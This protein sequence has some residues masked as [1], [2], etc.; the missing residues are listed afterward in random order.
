VQRPFLGTEA[1]AAG[2]VNRYQLATRHDALFRNVYVPKGHAV[3]PVDKAVGA[4]LWS[5]RCATAAGMS[6]AALHG[7]KWIDATLPAE[8]NQASRHRTANILL[9]SDFLADD[10]ICLVRGISATTPARTAFDLGRR[11]GLATAVMRLDALRQATRL[12]VD[13]VHALVGRHRGARGIVQLR[14]ALALSDAKAESPQET[15]TRLVLTDAG[16]RPTHTQIEVYD[17]DDFVARI[18]MGYL[19]WKVGVEYDGP[20][21]WTDSRVRDRDLERRARLAALDWRIVHVNAEM[22]RYRPAVIVGRTEAALSDAG[23]DLRRM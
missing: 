9:H 22:L 19:R 10:E 20:Q 15:R 5:G 18:D 23:A 13:D 8:L 16:M 3:T 2:V 12:R 7:M 14:H 6:A 21:H 11:K 4:W 1:L 17:H